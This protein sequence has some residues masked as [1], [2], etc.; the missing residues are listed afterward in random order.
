MR[1]GASLPVQRC[2]NSACNCKTKLGMRQSIEFTNEAEWSCNFA[3]LPSFCYLCSFLM[4]YEAYAQWKL[5]S[6]PGIPQE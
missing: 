5:G 4:G 3:W 1:F 6:I 2:A